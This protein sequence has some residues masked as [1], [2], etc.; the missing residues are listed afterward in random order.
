MQKG[1]EKR[2]R[3]QMIGEKGRWGKHDLGRKKRK[4][5]PRKEINKI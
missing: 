4:R 1:D 2:K 3:G 5:E